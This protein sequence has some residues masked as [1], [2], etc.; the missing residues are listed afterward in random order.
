MGRVERRGCS[1]SQALY[2]CHEAKLVSSGHGVLFCV[3]QFISLSWYSFPWALP[4]PGPGSPRD[5][6]SSSRDFLM[7]LT[8]HESLTPMELP[9]GTEM[10]KSHLA[11]KAG[12]VVALRKGGEGR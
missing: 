3:L 7:S 5:L 6:P 11:L 4:A 9:G 8:D 10:V 1:S 12:V 2:K